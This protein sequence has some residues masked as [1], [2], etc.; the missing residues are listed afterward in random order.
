MKR[1]NFTTQDKINELRLDFTN[2]ESKNKIFVLLEGDSDVRLYRKLYPH[3]R[4][5]VETIPGGKTQL[6]RGLRILN[7]NFAHLVGIRDADFAHLASEQPSLPNLFLTD[8]HDTEM[9]MV[10]SDDTF[11]VI[12]HEFTNL[13]QPAQMALRQQLLTALSPMGYLRW[14]NERA[15]LGI[16]FEKLSFGT[17]FDFANMKLPL[18]AFLRRHFTDDRVTEIIQEVEGMHQAEHD[19]YQLCNGHD[20]LK[21]LALYLTSLNPRGVNE[22]NIAS[23]FRVAYTFA[24]FARTQLHQL[25]MAWLTDKGIA[26]DPSQ[27]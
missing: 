13:D 7:V 18:E 26:I 2:P 27:G 14:Y 15:G 12:A 23:H 21:V 25:F 19:S 8:L 16:A 5:K 11:A 9:M 3:P 22:Q 1:D 4:L 6:E 17:L 24:A 10:A 20:F